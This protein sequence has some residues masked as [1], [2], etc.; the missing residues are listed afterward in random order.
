[1]QTQQKYT[2]LTNSIRMPMVGRLA[3]FHSWTD[4]FN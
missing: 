1:M 4:N 2:N 3:L